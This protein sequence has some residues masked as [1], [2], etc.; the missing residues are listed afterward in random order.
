MDEHTI[1]SGKT[2]AITAYITIVGTLIAIFMNLDD[3]NP[4]A[5]FHTRQAFGIAILFFG[6]AAIVPF[7]DSWLVSASFYI[8]VFVLWGFGIVNA[9][10][11]VTRPIPLVGSIFQKWLTFI[12]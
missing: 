7:F 3:K 2:T 1:N 8:F 9:I 11:G 10:Q 6:L 4:Y 12:G 5:T